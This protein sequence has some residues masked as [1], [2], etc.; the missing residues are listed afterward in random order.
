M[1]RSRAARLPLLPLL[2]ALL[3][4]GAPATAKDEA[5]S[6]RRLS[7]AELLRGH[8]ASPPAPQPLTATKPVSAPSV[9]EPQV[10]EPSAPAAAA[11]VPPAQPPARPA[12]PQRTA[13]PD[14]KPAVPIPPG[15]LPSVGETPD[16]VTAPWSQARPLGV[17]PLAWPGGPALPEPPLPVQSVGPLP[18]PAPELKEGRSG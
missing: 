13:G 12:E 6:T 8:A 10:R 14:R 18:A 5:A 3:L 11:V 16:A 1:A 15:L 17:A 2:T 9:V 4:A 7:G